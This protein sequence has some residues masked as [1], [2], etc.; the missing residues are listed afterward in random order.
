MS[1]RLM[2]ELI[3]GA[4]IFCVGYLAES[5]VRWAHKHGKLRNEG[6][7]KV[8][9]DDPELSARS[10]AVKSACSR[11][12]YRLFRSA[13]IFSSCAITA[14]KSRATVVRVSD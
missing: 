1:D 4:L 3:G 5:F 6:S 12:A 10:A 9:R 11:K 13:L 7:D 14:S 8:A 2:L